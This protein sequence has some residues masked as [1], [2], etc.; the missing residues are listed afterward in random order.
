MKDPYTTL[1]VSRAASRDEVK[2]AYRKRA[3]RAHPDRSGG[4]HETMAELN[5]AYALLEDPAKRARYDAGE[6]PDAPQRT[7]EQ[8]AEAMLLSAMEAVY[9]THSDTQDM[10][11]ALRGTLAGAMAAQRAEVAKARRAEAKAERVLRC[12][13]GGE[14]FRPFLEAKAAEARR[15]AATV[16]HNLEVLA[17]ATSYAEAVRWED[18]EAEAK[19]PPRGVLGGWRE[20]T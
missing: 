20:F 8:Q 2:R 9:G 10:A 15:A 1:G 5:R 13:R 3:K 18:P 12:L 4:S 11:A 16:A 17:L 7:L 19:R 6:D 14:R